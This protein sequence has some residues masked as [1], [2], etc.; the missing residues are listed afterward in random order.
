MKT[1]PLISM[2]QWLQKIL[3]SLTCTLVLGHNIFPHHHHDEAA[4]IEHHH[5]HDDDDDHDHN[6]YSFGQLDESFVPAKIQ[7]GLYCDYASIIF[8]QPVN[9]FNF[10]LTPF[11][12]KPEYSFKKEFPPPG[13]YHHKLSLRG[14]P[15]A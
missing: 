4:A 9:E 1:L 10:E 2:N 8:A 3:I 6:I 11:N 15:V 12:K 14:P 5:G 13:N 7:C